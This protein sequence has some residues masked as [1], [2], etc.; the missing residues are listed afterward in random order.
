MIEGKVVSVVIRE[1]LRTRLYLDEAYL[2]K[3]YQGSYPFITV[4]QQ[5]LPGEQQEFPAS[6]Y[7]RRIILWPDQFWDGANLKL[8]AS[9]TY[10]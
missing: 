5:D 9:Y 10:T 2:R 1:Y 8:V 4:I 3:I 6:E 7:S